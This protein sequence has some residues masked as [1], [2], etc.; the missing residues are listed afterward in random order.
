MLLS[1]HL[2][3][4]VERIADRVM[5]LVGGQLKV[6]TSMSDFASRVSGF[7]IR[8]EK[9]DHERLAAIPGLIEA[10]RTGDWL[11]LS[12]ADCDDE[13]MAAIERAGGETAEPIEM[14]FGDG[15]LAYLSRQRGESSFLNLHR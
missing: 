10:R 14:T 1:T 4:D 2:L 7:A 8:V 12:V 6:D 13:T 15:V 11:R 9:I 3:D 5:V